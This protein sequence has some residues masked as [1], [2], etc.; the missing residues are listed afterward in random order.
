MRL[1]SAQS[2]KQELL[3]ELVD[4]LSALA[5]RSLRLNALS[6]RASVRA[7]IGPTASFGIGAAPVGAASPVQRSVALGI[8]P[9]SKGQYR[10]AVRIQRQ[11]LHES[12]IVAGIRA[13]AKGEVEVRTVGRIAKRSPA[14]RPAAASADDEPWHQQRR[15]PL[16]PGSS[17][18]HFKVTAGTLGAFVKRKGRVHILSN[19]HV[20]ANEDRASARDAILQPGPFDGGRR[21]RDR[22]ASLDR[23]IRLRP[24]GAN[25]VDA[26]LG[27][28]EVEDFDASTLRRIVGGRNRRLA[29]VGTDIDEGMRVYKVGRTT[30]ATAGRVTAFALDNVVVAFDAGNV[31]FDDQVEIESAGSRPFSDGGDSGSLIVNAD[32][33]AVALL[34]AGSDSGGRRD[35]GLTYASPIRAVLKALDA[36]LLH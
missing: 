29:G 31:R 32:I 36:T 2:L 6:A 20:L 18:A 8:A 26:A 16:L 9:G 10:L 17:V 33:Q 4:P 23:W 28:L 11:G 35:L 12:S 7:A 1:D 5:I 14:A 21:T 22:V 19:N 24:S 13:R 34:F 3:S 30:G 27:L 15:R 25:L